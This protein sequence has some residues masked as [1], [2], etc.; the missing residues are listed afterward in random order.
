MGR[1]KKTMILITHDID[2]AIYLSDRIIILKNSP[3]SVGTIIDCNE[4]YRP[5][6]R[7]GS[8]FAYVRQKVYKE[9]FGEAEEYVD[10]VI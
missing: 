3:A 6:N 7:T 2:E 8:N 1:R 10:Y 4:L 9:F 5:R